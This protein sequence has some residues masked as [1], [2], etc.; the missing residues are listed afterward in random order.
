MR[1]EFV[2]PAKLLTAAENKP[3]FSTW[4]ISA[5]DHFTKNR[6]QKKNMKIFYIS[7]KFRWYPEGAQNSFFKTALTP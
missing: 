6:M 3:Q 5:L 2:P 1:N 4:L 7:N